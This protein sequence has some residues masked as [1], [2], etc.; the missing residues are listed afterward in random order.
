MLEKIKAYI[1][2]YKI[3]NKGDKVVVA[4]SGG[5]D[6]LAL[7]YAL[8]ELRS[9]YQIELAVAHVNHMFRQESKEEALFVGQ[10]ARRLGTGYYQ[11]EVN[12]PEYIR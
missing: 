4:C 10:V 12:V 5:P 1:Q 6:S 7:L 9:Y 3:L 8:S 11:T 2:R